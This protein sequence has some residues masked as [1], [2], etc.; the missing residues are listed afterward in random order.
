MYRHFITFRIRKET[1]EREKKITP[2]HVN[3][4]NKKKKILRELKWKL[5]ENHI[6]VLLCVHLCRV[7]F[8]KL[9]DVQWH[10][11]LWTSTRYFL[12]QIDCRYYIFKKYS[13]IIFGICIRFSHRCMNVILVLHV[14]C[15]TSDC[16]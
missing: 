10:K 5:C 16:F 6:T 14:K 1:Q 13:Q 8:R 2:P 11:G 4:K 15:Y 7:I 12:N 9:R 3:L